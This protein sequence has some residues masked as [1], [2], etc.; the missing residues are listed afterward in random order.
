[1]ATVTVMYAAKPESK[2][3]MDYYLNTHM[4]MVEA[5]WGP[6][7][8]RGYKVLRG[9]PGADGAA[10]PYH[11]LVNLDFTSAAAFAASVAETGAKVMGD[12]PNFTDIQ[13]SLQVN[14][15]IAT[16]ENAS[17]A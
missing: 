9:T 15:V 6:S 16:Y 12:V 11:V 3:D 2:F 7:G 17:P 10:P 8:L 14:D 1:M 4:K 13:P 5:S